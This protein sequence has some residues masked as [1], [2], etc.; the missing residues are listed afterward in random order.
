MFSFSFEF[1]WKKDF[2]AMM[3]IGLINYEDYLI[4]VI[5]YKYVNTIERRF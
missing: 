2:I 5:Q 4:I 3:D 1:D